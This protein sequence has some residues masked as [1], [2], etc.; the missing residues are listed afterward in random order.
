MVFFKRTL[1]LITAFVFGVL[2]AALYFAPHRSA[3]GA[4][5][6]LVNWNRIVAA[7][8]LLLATYSLVR[9]HLKKVERRVS[10]W[11]YSALLLISFGVTF[12][13]GIYNDGMWAFQER[14][15]TGALPWI[16]DYIFKPAGSTMFSVLAFFIASAAYRSFR[17]KTFSAGL[18]LFS[19]LVM[20]L[21]QI[22][23]GRMISDKLPDFSLWLM[24]APNTAVKRG[25]LLGVSLGIVATSVR[26]IFGV[27]R[28]YLGGE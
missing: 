23:V 8:A 17:A 13:F 2:G 4:Y 16:Y 7:F 28:G 10:G 24:T 3:A 9:V 12:F 5:T 18:L 22:P 20:M 6:Q 15:T 26:I 25:I 11:G 14:E 21:G 19:A 1:P 27:E